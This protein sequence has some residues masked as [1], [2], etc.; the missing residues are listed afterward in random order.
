MNKLTRE[1]EE[2]NLLCRRMPNNLCRSFVLKEVEHA[3]SDFLPKNTV[4]K[5]EQNE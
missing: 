3:H 5:S 1:R 4:E 2:T